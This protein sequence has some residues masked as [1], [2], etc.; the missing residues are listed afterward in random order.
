MTG[1]AAPA[2]RLTT[3]VPGLDVVL[4]GGFLIGG[5]YIFQGQAGAGKT[6][7]GNQMCF[8]HAAGGGRALYVTL[9]S[10]SH[11]RMMAHMSVLSFFDQTAIPDRL[12][13]L[14]AFR[15]LEEKGLDGLLDL[16]RREMRASKAGLLVLDG[17]VAA[18]ESAT[19]AREF[20][21]FIHE[22][23]TLTA[24][25]ESSAFLLTSTGASPLPVAAEH[26]MVDGVIDM[27]DRLYGRRS[28]R[29]FQVLKRRGGGYL[30]GRHS[31]RITADGI[32]VHPRTEALL[33]RP[34]HTDIP[35]RDRI[36]TGVPGVDRALG[37]GLLH[38]TTT[39]VIG[40]AGAGKTTLG[41]HFLS[42]CSVDEPGLLFG[43]YETPERVASQ[44]RS[45]D[46]PLAD[47][48]STDV[49]EAL[50][51]PA[52]EGLL[53][54][55]CEQL[56]DAVRRRSVRRL[57]LDGIDGLAKLAVEPDR[58]GHVMTALS[59]EL[60]ALGVT[61]LYTSEA[62]LGAPVLGNA[63]A[64]LSI[65]GVSAVAENA[66]VMRFVN[67]NATHYRLISVLKARNSAID[68]HWHSYR[69]TDAGIVVESDSA[70]AERVLNSLTNDTG[71]RYIA[72][73]QE[74]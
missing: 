41:L 6:I 53:D 14:S 38:P 16:L 33:W 11:S 34:T 36:S 22:L 26:T 20:K 68:D 44:A 17:L 63:Y 7:L 43:F 9:L 72:P 24:L 73:H 39:L 55:I 67:L 18:E 54:E 35:D 19:S 27:S 40:P 56:V 74:H 70:E 46:L 12:T 8:H 15:E 64:G 51:Q 13:Y 58:I 66:I 30:E 29:D 47:H 32:V 59:N 3:G 25:N 37:G 49:V 21:K 62:E 23:Q 50:W 71:G 57:F 52:T 65:K 61:T 60:R 4:D 28:E 45:L 69:M 10:E 5:V 31:F 48:L 1:F 42:E 2:G